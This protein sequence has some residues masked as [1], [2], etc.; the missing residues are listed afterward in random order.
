M[1]KVLLFFVAVFAT[2]MLFAQT[3]PT[4]PD[5]TKNWKFGGL[6]S[7]TLNQVSL[8]NWQAGGENSVSANFITKLNADYQKNKFSWKNSLEIGYGLTQQGSKDPE[9]TDDRIEYNTQVGH[10]MNE[11]WEFNGFASFRTQFADGFENAEDSLK[12]STFMAPAYVLAGLGF[13][14]KFKD[15][16]T[17][18]LSPATGKLTIVNDD[19]LSEEGRYGV[20]PG[21]KTRMEL[22]GYVKI[23]IKREIMENVSLETKA[24]FFSNYLENAGNIDINWDVLISMKVNKWLSANLTTNLIYDDDIDIVAKTDADGN[25]TEVGPRTQFKQVFGAGLSYKF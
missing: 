12:I 19:R 20:D 10:N 25:P 5:S 11:R 23:H 6:F 21:D 2:P 3:Q 1:K 16:F 18:N 14:Y 22:G 7:L 13:E 4:Q 24:D 17:A 9:K 8:T 15:W